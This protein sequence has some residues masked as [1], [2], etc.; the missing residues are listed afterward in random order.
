MLFRS[1]QQMAIFCLDILN[2]KLKMPVPGT[3]YLADNTSESKGIP[4]ISNE[5]VSE[6]LWYSCQFWMDHC[7][8]MSVTSAPSAVLAAIQEL[9]ER[10]FVQW[11]EICTSKGSFTGIN[12]SFLTWLKVSIVCGIIF[13]Y[14]I[15]QSLCYQECRR[16]YI[17]F[18]IYKHCHIC[19]SD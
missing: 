19:R 4:Y 18:L 14:L 12:L 5:S 2:E 9:I 6:G 1:E 10:N 11:I 13:G 7:I 8:S 16:W 15:F 17:Q 3:G